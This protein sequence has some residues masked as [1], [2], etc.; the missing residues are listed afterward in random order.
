MTKGSRRRGSGDRILESR[1][2]IGLFLGVVILCAVFFSLGYVMGK[3]Q[4]SGSVHAAFEP[5]SVPAVPAVPAVEKEK[6]VRRESPSPAAGDWDF[7]ADKSHNQIEPPAPDEKSISPAPVHPRRENTP[8]I[9]PLDD[10]KPTRASSL[11]VRSVSPK[12]SNG[13]VIFQV[14]AVTRQG[15]ALAMADALQR[16]KFPSFVLAPSNDNFYR[17]QVGPYPDQRSAD[18]ARSALDRAG[19][20]TII[21]R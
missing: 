6:V 4:Y 1:H 11:S 18:A 15:D 21:R 20:K 8:F 2:L 17:V 5:H 12:T 16:K 14:A 9:V 19:F 10:R 7:Y 3:S 13:A